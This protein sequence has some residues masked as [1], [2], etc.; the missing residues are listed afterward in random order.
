MAGAGDPTYTGPAQTGFAITTNNASV[1]VPIST[2]INIILGTK[3]WVGPQTISVGNFGVVTGYTF[4]PVITNYAIPTGGTPSS[5]TMFA[6]QTDFDTMVLSLFDFFLTT[7]NTAT[8][9]NSSVYVMTG[10]VAQADLSLSAS[11]GTGTI[12]LGSAEAYYLTVSNA[13][14][15]TA[16]GVV[17]SNQIPAYETFYSVT[18]GAT[19]A[20]GVLLVNLGSLAA[21]AATNVT[22]TVYPTLPAGVANGQLTN[23]FQVFASTTDPVLTNNSATVVT[24][25]SLP[26]PGT[27]LTISGNILFAAGFVPTIILDISVFGSGPIEETGSA[28]AS[29][30]TAVTTTPGD[31][32]LLNNP[33][34]GNN[35]TNW[36]AVAR[37]FNPADLT[38][39]NGL[40]ATESQTFFAT[41]FG[42]SG[43][44]GFQLFPN[45]YFT[46]ATSPNTANG[47][48]SITSV[49]TELTPA[50][51][52][53]AASLPTFIL[54]V[55]S[56]YTDLSLSAGAAPQP[57]TV[58]SNLVYTLTVSN[59]LNASYA[60]QT[61]TAT[62]VVVSNR[63]PAN[64]T[65]VSATGGATPSGGVLLMNLGSLAEGT[66]VSVQVTVQ[67]T[68]AG[69]LTNNFQV[70]A[71]EFDPNVTN[72][73]ASVVSTV[74][75]AAVALAQAVPGTPIAW[76]NPGGSVVVT[77]TFGFAGNPVPIQTG[78]GGYA[79][80]TGQP[81]DLVLLFTNN[82]VMSPTNWAAVERFFNP[83]DP[84]G[85]QGLAATYS[86][87][88][89]ATNF[90]GSGFNGYQLFPVVSYIPEG[91]VTTNANG[92]I[93]IL[94][95]YTEFGPVGG[96][97]AGQQDI[98]VVTLDT[99]T[100]AVNITL[101]T[102]AQVVSSA[103]FTVTGTATNYINSA[104]TNV[105]VQL[106]GGGWT[107]ASSV[108]GWSNWTANVTLT[109]GSNTVS[110]YAV[111]GYGSFS[112]DQHGDV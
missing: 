37:F 44:N 59:A 5:Y 10:I 60:P 66:N 14:P 11:T 53:P 32:I 91:T 24:A 52:L 94:A 79:A 101:P 54:T 47:I 34:G 86:Q 62:G 26:F 104:V 15:A 97:N 16:T 96:I 61:V 43:F 40:A 103:A 22:L 3:Q 95:T 2:N 29:G 74:T 36:L 13:G 9:T 19:P 85:T 99:L 87:T 100:C 1:T 111:N 12:T 76:T 20:N 57:V 102:P 8:Y 27:P 65:F 33:T 41:N 4:D 50:G 98:D 71:N 106:N 108:N 21:G 56:P 109:P 28:T 67:P 45:T 69:S 25:V 6:G 89:F 31:V 48:T 18:G 110:A 58:G 112:T 81:G 55:T 77:Y 70:F 49:Y 107:G 92:L 64:C 82:G 84:T 72:N 7:T 46:P 30:F 35:P 38:G 39:T 42:G 90:G 17:I 51:A 83:A 88:F 93:T 80:N 23:Q 73:S 78:A 68:A 63:I 75:N 105:F